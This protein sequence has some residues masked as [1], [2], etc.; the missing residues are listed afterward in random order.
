MERLE[1]NAIEILHMM[2]ERSECIIC[3]SGGKDSSVLKHIALQ[4][5]ENM[6]CNSEFV[7]ITQQWMHRKRS[8][9]FGK[10]NESLNRWG[11][12]MKFIIQKEIEA[13]MLFI[14]KAYGNQ[15]TVDELKD[16]ESGLDAAG[17]VIEFNMI[18]MGIAEEMNKRMDKMMK[19]FQSGK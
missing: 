1:K 18:D 4:A 2:C 11:F 9:L 3:D 10:K 5:K 19:N 6:G 16:A 12:R 7:I 15:F 14:C 8:I 13:M 17:I